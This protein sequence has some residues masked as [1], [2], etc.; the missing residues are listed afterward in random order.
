[1]LFL[2]VTLKS[3]KKKVKKEERQVRSKY[4]LAIFLIS[5]SSL[6]FE[7][8]LTRIFSVTLWYHFGFLIISTVL[9]GFGVSGV[10]LSLWQKFHERI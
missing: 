6:L 4:N 9:L 10:L 3:Q 8:S 7:L 1:M 2:Q 5:F